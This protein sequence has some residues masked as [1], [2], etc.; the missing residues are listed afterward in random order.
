MLAAST[1]IEAAV[2]ADEASTHGVV[3]E[4]DAAVGEA[5]TRGNDLAESSPI[6]PL[7]VH[8]LAHNTVDQSLEQLVL[9]Q[10]STLAAA[11]EASQNST[12]Q[13]EQNPAQSSAS[14]PEPIGAADAS[15]AVS[16][17]IAQEAPLP[18]SP[19]DDQPELIASTSFNPGLVSLPP[20]QPA[21]YDFDTEP[22]T[23]TAPK[24]VFFNLHKSPKSPF[25]KF[26]SH[27]SNDQ[28]HALQAE[29]KSSDEPLNYGDPDLLSRDK[30][31]QKDAVRR[32]LYKRIRNDWT[33]TWPAAEL[34][35]A[36]IE[37]AKARACAVRQ[38]IVSVE[39]A[40]LLGPSGT[41]ASPLP[42]TASHAT[43][44]LAAVSVAVAAD[45][46]TEAS[47]GDSTNLG[48]ELDSDT[49]SIYSTVSEDTSCLR[50]RSEWISDISE[51]E[52]IGIYYQKMPTYVH[53]TFRYESPDA[54]VAAVNV[55]VEVRKAKARRDMRAE[56]VWN[57]GLACFAA[58]RDAWTGARLVHVKLSKPAPPTSP[59]S[60]LR[61]L[62][63]LH[64]FTKHDSAPPKLVHGAGAVAVDQKT[65]G[66]DFHSHS[67]ST[68]PT[69]AVLV[70]TMPL[71]PVVSNSRHSLRS[72][73]S[74]HSRNSQHSQQS[75]L[76]Q[77][78]TGAETAA[79]T[80]VTSDYGSGA[81]LDGN[82]HQQSVPRARLPHQQD[83]DVET[84]VP[85]LPPL[86]PPGNPMRA[87]ITPSIYLSLYDKLVL[88]CLRP[89]CP[90]NLC[91]MIGSCVAGW[92]RDNEWLPPRPV[93]APAPVMSAMSV[94]LRKKRRNDR[95]DG[96][97]DKR[98]VQSNAAD[99]SKG[100]PASPGLGRRMSSFLSSRPAPASIGLPTTT[101]A[102]NSSGAGSTSP[103]ADEKD[104]EG[105]GG[106][107]GL[108]RSLQRVLGLG[109]VA[110]GSNTMLGAQSSGHG[111][112]VS[113]GAVGQS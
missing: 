20:S 41:F 37:A 99:G 43:V 78:S 94:S 40:G 44:S 7:H 97:K 82:R 101:T 103:P 55:P 87:S 9:A 42:P 69:A 46:A 74:Q 75:Q 77:Q 86:L 67:I 29:A 85:V 50:P 8:D 104:E 56:I 63:R 84:M 22:E 113:V 26:R 60:P 111:H 76:S 18:I 47:L 27:H 11:Q 4:M 100:G 88:N 105:S 17:V 70:G 36:S 72:E 92:K 14:H 38:Q 15:A 6:T 52:N 5:P 65:M 2:Y 106:S 16:D 10:V 35:P 39:Q 62:F 24:M 21:Q 73:H 58:R 1:A 107:R 95:R 102:S 89:S 59:T 45:A 83:C 12:S 30:S 23:E 112:S 19:T 57:E 68:I 61:G 34:S 98:D 3:V 32:Y 71:T 25:A 13:H 48:D 90:V 110:H 66:H 91:D 96:Q 81:D 64:S 51:D 49:H 93:A 80:P 109:H 28:Q 33:F 79:S 54:V 31:K 53:S 108:R